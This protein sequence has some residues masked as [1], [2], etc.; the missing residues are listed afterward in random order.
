[1]PEEQTRRWSEQYLKGPFNDSIEQIESALRAMEEVQFMGA[2]D[3]ETIRKVSLL[4]P[5]F[6][7]SA[8]DAIV[9]EM[10]SRLV[11][12]DIAARDYD[13]GTKEHEAYKEDLIARVHRIDFDSA[14]KSDVA[15]IGDEADALDASLFTL[16]CVLDNFM[17]SMFGDDHQF[18]KTRAETVKLAVIDFIRMEEY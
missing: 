3:G 2:D 17:Q 14:V 9:Y 18:S 8:I 10:V 5:E 7:S 11:R 16:L 12:R 4:H 13:W 1:M 6:P 15:F